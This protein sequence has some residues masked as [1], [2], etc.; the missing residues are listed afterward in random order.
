MSKLNTNEIMK[1]TQ[2]T[3]Q[4]IAHLK[5]LIKQR[6]NASK[7]Q[8]KGIRAKMRAMGFY[9]SEFGIYDCQVEDIDRL[10]SSGT[11]KVIKDESSYHQNIKERTKKEDTYHIENKAKIISSF[12][13][14]VGNNPRIL[15]LGTMPG[16]ESLRTGH[17]YANTRNSFWKIMA[18]IFNGGDLPNLFEKR[19]DILRENG[20]ALW[21]T[22]ANCTREGSQ[23]TNI[24]S[25]TINDI[26]GLLE[27]FP[28]INM[29]IFNGKKAASFVVPKINYKVAP[30]TSSANTIRY[31]KKLLEWKTALLY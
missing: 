6:V 17:Y 25:E 30:S 16:P 18:D 1:K 26:Q 2:Y 3:L 29:V 27:T 4:E 20:I 12:P 24:Q 14:M 11:I 21:D 22:L 13:P 7:E 5:Q 23:D 19:Y 15:I 10:I 31:E 28:T 8:Q 9:G